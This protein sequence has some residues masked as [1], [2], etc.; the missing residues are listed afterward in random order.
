MKPL[1]K[2]TSIKALLTEAAFDKQT[3]ILV[4]AAI[5]KDKIWQAKRE[6]EKIANAPLVRARVAELRA[7]GQFNAAEIVQISAALGVFLV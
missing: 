4:T 5:E 1:Q 3:K 7:K 2:N 6:A